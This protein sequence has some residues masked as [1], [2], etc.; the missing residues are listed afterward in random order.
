MCLSSTEG[1]GTSWRKNSSAISEPPESRSPSISSSRTARFRAFHTLIAGCFA[2]MGR[3][4]FVSPGRIHVARFGIGEFA[5][6]ASPCKEHFH[7][8]GGGIEEIARGIRKAGCGKQSSEH[9]RSTARFRDGFSVFNVRRPLVSCCK[10]NQGC[11]TSGGL[12]GGG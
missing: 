9:C 11:S 2:K 12:S 6:S 3:N 8:T 1:S 4:H 10:H 7:V 5:T